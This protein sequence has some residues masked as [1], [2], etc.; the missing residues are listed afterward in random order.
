[1]TG[2]PRASAFAH[3]HEDP[4]TMR[5]ALAYT[6]AR[7]RFGRA[8]VEKDYFCTLVLEHLG[9]AECGLVFKGGTCL[10]KVHSGFYRMSEDLDFAVP[11]PFDTPRAARS[12]AAKPVKVALDALAIPGVRV[13]KPLSGAN[14]STQYAATL[15]YE[16]VLDA[17]GG[18]IVIEV[19]LREPALS[20]ISLGE[21][22]TLL[23]D[24]VSGESLVPG[25]RI[26]CLSRLEAMA[27][28]L[29]AALTRKDPAVR[30][31]YDLDHAERHANFDLEASDL[32]DLLERKLIVPGTGELDV[33]EA[34]F[35]RLHGQLDARLRPVLRPADYASFDLRRAFDRVAAISKHLGKY[36]GRPSFSGDES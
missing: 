14:N 2:D 12:K 34:R 24:P 26:P 23:T 3:P 20:E 5:D 27:E 1:V 10:A 8:L 18:T 29:R 21:A 16:S 13:E 33:S 28:K 36:G 35:D 25:V 4:R 15:R 11:I 6:A 17:G 32:V 22:R 9:R 7:T 31:Y 19:A 30:D